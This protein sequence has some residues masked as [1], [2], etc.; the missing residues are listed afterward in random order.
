MTYDPN[1]KAN[2][3]IYNGVEY[4]SQTESKYAESFDSLE[5]GFENWP[6]VFRGEGLKY[7]PDFKLV[8]TGAIFEVKGNKYEEMEQR[9]FRLVVRQGRELFV[10]DTNGFLYKAT[11]TGLDE[12]RLVRC[13]SC[14]KWYVSGWKPSEDKPGYGFTQKCPNGCEQSRKEIRENIFDATGIYV[15]ERERQW[16]LGEYPNIAKPENENW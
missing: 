1:I 7:K 12:A 16:P 4:E 8:D 11:E 6:Y 15:Y 14:G 10:G 3:T 2:K 13:L 9:K 5:I